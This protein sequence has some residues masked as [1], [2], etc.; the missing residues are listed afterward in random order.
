MIR[1]KS[2]FLAACTL[3]VAACGSTKSTPHT[4]S[5]SHALNAHGTWKS[6]GKLHGGNMEIAYDT[7]SLNVQADSIL[8]RNRVVVRDMSKENFLNTPQYKTAVS[9]WEF[10]CAK[11]TYRV[12]QTHF[13]DT[14][15]QLLAQHHYTPISTPAQPIQTNTPSQVLFDIA[16]GKH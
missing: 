13:F 14:K 16:C 8:L 7:G 6:I 3:F 2:L 9:E 11:R 1:S 12:L 15:K 4:P 10:S 5:Q